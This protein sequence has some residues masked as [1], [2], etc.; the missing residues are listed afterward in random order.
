[1]N[2]LPTIDIKGKAYVLVKDRVIE[3]N[4]KY[5][6]GSIVTKIINVSD[7]SVTYQAIVFPDAST[8]ERQFVAHSTDSFGKNIP[9]HE[10]AETSAV[11]RALA[12]MGIG[13]IDSIASADEMTKAKTYKPAAKPVS[14]S[15]PNMG[16]ELNDGTTLVTGT[17]NG[18]QWYGQRQTDGTMKWLKEEEYHAL[19]PKAPL[20]D[21]PF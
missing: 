8:P 7:K 9:A 17:K 11:G 5:P 4:E 1:M 16:V 14:S 3:F 19:I 2:N 13:V 20:D 18:K 10:N 21:L 12:L 6:K 15:K